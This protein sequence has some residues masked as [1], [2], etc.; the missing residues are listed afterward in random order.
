[1]FQR[2]LE[3]CIL[4]FGHSQHDEELMECLKVLDF[5]FVKILPYGSER[6]AFKRGVDPLCGHGGKR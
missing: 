2:L 5:L 4:C 1:M 6:V 3:R